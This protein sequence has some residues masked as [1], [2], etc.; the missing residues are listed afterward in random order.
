VGGWWHVR[1]T[2]FYWLPDVEL[3]EAAF[4]IRFVPIFFF[5]LLYYVF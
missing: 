4:E 3:S 5:L 2:Q 1:F